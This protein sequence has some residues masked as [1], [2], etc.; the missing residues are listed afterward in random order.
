MKKLQVKM[1]ILLTLNDHIGFTKILLVV[2]M[3]DPKMV[4][5]CLVIFAF[6][7]LIM[8]FVFLASTFNKKP[9]YMA[10]KGVRVR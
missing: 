4:Q 9:C 3:V 6:S 5:R 7:N 2:F 10:L 1:R 8:T